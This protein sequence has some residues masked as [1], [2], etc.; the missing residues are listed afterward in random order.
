MPA[1]PH[2]LTAVL[3]SAVRQRDHL[4]AQA[5]WERRAALGP[6]IP[7]PLHRQYVELLLSGGQGLAARRAWLAIGPT[8]GA[9]PGDAIWDG[10][11]EAGSLAGWGFSWHIGRLWGVEVTLDRFVAARGRHSLRLAFNAFP[12]LEFANVWQ[13][14]AL[15]P[16]R[17]Y[18]LRAMTKA[19][20]FNTQ[21]G[22]KFQIVSPDGERVLAET[23]TVSG[24]T[25]D[26]VPLETRVRVPGDL[27]L[28]R[29]RLRRERA[30]GPE[31]NL[32]GRVWIDEVSLTPI[33]SPLA[34]A[35]RQ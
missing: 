34:A 21:S 25:P 31:G 26:W 30:R 17:E 29:V 6:P 4:L 11:F 5:A 14:V 12:T 28:A 7:A 1:E 3:V 27:S 13:P 10:G 32:G 19:L 15:E 2:L 35:T 9:A 33:G 24:T 16:G 22:L 8:G 20:E 23:G 18:A